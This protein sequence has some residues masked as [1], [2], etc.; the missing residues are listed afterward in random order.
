MMVI[1]KD[2]F[3]RL[4]TVPGMLLFDVYL[5]DRDLAALM[6]NVV[7]VSFVRASSLFY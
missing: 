5:R 4:V 3:V 7:G 2:G 1:A 6:S